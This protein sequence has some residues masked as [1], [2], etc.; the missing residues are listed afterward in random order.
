[1]SFKSGQIIELSINSLAHG[2][3]GVGRLNDFVF[4]VPLTAPKDLVRAK[5]T[6]IKKN[7]GEAEL[8][9]I[10]KPSST[11]TKPVCDVFGE[12]GGCQWQHITYEEQLRQKQDIV[13]HALNRIAREE[14]F[15]LKPIIGSPEE[16]FYRNR[17]QLKTWGPQVGFYKRASHEIIEFDPCHII[18]KPLNAETDKIKSELKDAQRGQASK[19]EIFLTQKGDVARSTDKTHGKEFGFSQVNTKQNEQMKNYVFDLIGAPD[20]GK[21]LL[22]LYCGNGN[23]SLPLAEK[24]WNVCGIDNSE[25]A[26]AQAKKQVIIGRSQFFHDDCAKGVKKLL[27]KEYSFKKIIM[28][29]PRIGADEYLI[30]QLP[31]LDADTLV[32][33][34]CN[35]TTF[36]RDWARIKANSN[37]KLVSVQ[38]FDMFPQTFHVE[39]VA[40]AKITVSGIFAISDN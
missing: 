18:E 36:A 34:S 10:V 17:A 32:Y 2:G 25:A 35:P 24:G 19:V 12:C 33:V 27:K 9:E 1:M 37:F 5:I 40:L 22:D 6:T 15:E 4:F 8:L 21:T 20:K 28:D 16:F 31:K 13:K 23:F 11:R 26:I 30:K 38:P 7:Y 39:L 3:A 14:D 29:P